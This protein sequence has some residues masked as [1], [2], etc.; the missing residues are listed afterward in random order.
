MVLKDDFAC[1]SLLVKKT[2]VT[3]SKIDF[4]KQFLLAKHES[5]EIYEHLMILY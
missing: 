4:K 5:V 2:I 3:I 1:W